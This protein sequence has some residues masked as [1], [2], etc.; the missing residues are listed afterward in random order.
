[1]K[2]HLEDKPYY[3]AF[4][5][6]YG[7]GPMRYKKLM[8]IFG[9]LKTAYQANQEE[10]TQVL[11]LK[12]AI[13]FCRFRNTFNLDK[14]LCELEKKEI[15]L[16]SQI[17]PLYPP[18]LLELTDAPICLYVKGKIDLY[19]WKDM[20]ILAI[21]GTRQP[22]AYGSQLA[23][24]FAFELAQAG[25][26]VIS[27]MALGVDAL[28]HEGALQANGKTIAV[29]G[30]GVDI[31]SPPSNRWIYEKILKNEGLIISEFPPGHL[32]MKGLFV[33]RNRIIS[34]ISAGVLVIE[35]TKDSGALITARYAAEQGREVYAV[36]GPISSSLSAAP[37]SLLKQ[38]AALV[39]ETQDIMNGFGVKKMSKNTNLE[40]DQNLTKTEITIIKLLQ[41]ETLLTDEIINHL[42][43]DSIQ[44]SQLLS[45]LEIKGL[46]EKTNDGKYQLV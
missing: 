31:V 19:N 46:I 15:I 12:I 43:S 21:V 37:N 25:V 3:L 11:G 18:H 42:K 23:K 40:T 32:V 34:G 38:G 17:D 7:I 1:M 36:P 2:K 5:Y 39:S 44:V 20:M 22:T 16:V 13:D 9:D 26:T 45:S 24:K 33:A 10:L 28:A 14:T 4:S 29:L 35:G 30:C 27:G 6:C 8:E 41:K